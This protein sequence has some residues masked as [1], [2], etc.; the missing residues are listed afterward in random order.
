LGFNSRSEPPVGQRRR[1]KE[2]KQDED[3][4]T[5]KDLVE[6]AVRTE[7]GLTPLG[8]MNTEQAQALPDEIDAVIVDT[9]HKTGRMKTDVASDEPASATKL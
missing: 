6:V 3:M 7:D 5:E 4:T 9:D 1:P 8:I 2:L